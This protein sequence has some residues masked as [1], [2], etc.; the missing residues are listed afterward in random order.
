LFNNIL[1]QGNTI[2]EAIF[3]LTRKRIFEK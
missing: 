1:I 3:A 2:N